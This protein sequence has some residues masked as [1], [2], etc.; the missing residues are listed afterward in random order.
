MG[1]LEWSKRSKRLVAFVLDAD[2]TVEKDGIEKVFFYYQQQG[3]AVGS[4]LSSC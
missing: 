3:G 4:S 2:L 1:M